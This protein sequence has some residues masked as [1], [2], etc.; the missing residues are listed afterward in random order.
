VVEAAG[1]APW[2]LLLLLLLLLLGVL[3]QV[4]P[5]CCLLLLPVLQLCWCSHWGSSAGRRGSWHVQTS[6]GS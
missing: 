4:L 2:A 3:L 1:V 5:D 6:A